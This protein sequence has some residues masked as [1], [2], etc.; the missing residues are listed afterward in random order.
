MEVAL[1]E[2]RDPTVHKKLVLTLTVALPALALTAVPLVAQAA[3]TPAVQIT[4]AQYDSPGS[5]TRSNTSLNNEWVR[6]TN[7]TSK[8]IQLKGWTVRDKANHVYTFATAYTLGAG[9]RV[10]VHTG[11]GTNSRPDAQ[12]VYWQSGNYI[13]NNTGDTITVRSN[14]GRAV[15]T[16]TYRPR[17]GDNGVSYC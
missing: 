10:Y 7:T 5:D 3:A 2:R 11:K 15:D 1:L 12:H 4:K 9:R 17:S 16:C 14:T 6:L 8:P 13:W